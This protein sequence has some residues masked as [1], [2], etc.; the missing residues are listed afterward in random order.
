MHRRF[1]TCMLRTALHAAVATCNLSGCDLRQESI[2]QGG[3][4]QNSS[5][6]VTQGRE[7]P[8]QHSRRR[9][10]SRRG[11]WPA[12]AAATAARSPG[13]RAI[14]RSGCARTQRTRPQVCGRGCCALA[15]QCYTLHGRLLVSHALPLLVLRLHDF[16]VACAAQGFGFARGRLKVA[17]L[18]SIGCCPCCGCGTRLRVCKGAI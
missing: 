16:R 13:R 5:E 3:A 2:S 12:S 11:C 1:C 15:C 6:G 10:R 9:R 18:A 8:R 4:S 7:R 14:R 17:Y